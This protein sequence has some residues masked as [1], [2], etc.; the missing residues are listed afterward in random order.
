M[1]T[2]KCP[3]CKARDHRGQY[4]HPCAAIYRKVRRFQ[5]L[6]K[7]DKVIMPHRT[8]AGLVFFVPDADADVVEWLDKRGK[9]PDM[10]AVRDKAL[11]MTIKALLEG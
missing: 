6:I 2:H 1:K 7:D 8:P 4:C 11:R 5:R 10:Q 9:M 3:N